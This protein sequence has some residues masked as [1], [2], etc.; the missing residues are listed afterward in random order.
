MPAQFTLLEV[1][2]AASCRGMLLAMPR[3][4]VIG[5]ACEGFSCHRAAAAARQRVSKSMGQGSDDRAEPR[6]A[7]SEIPAGRYSAQHTWRHSNPSLC[8]HSTNYVQVKI[9]KQ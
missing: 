1:S 2:L 6:H 5:T 4:V 9:C 8:C 7:E 3:G